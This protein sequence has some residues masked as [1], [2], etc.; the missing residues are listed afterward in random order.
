MTSPTGTNL[1][2]TLALR[3]YPF[4]NGRKRL[5]RILARRW[6]EPFLW[7]GRWGIRYLLVGRNYVDQRIARDGAYE[8]EQIDY[9]C[10]EVTRSAADVF[11]D[12]GAN[13]GVYSLSVAART[14]CPNIIAFEPDPY[15]LSQLQANIFLNGYC[16]RICVVAAGV[17]N[18]TGEAA[19]LV[20]RDDSD[21]CTA[22]SSM[23]RTTGGA[24]ESISI[25]TIALDDRYDW[26]GR[27]IVVKMDIEGHEPQALQGMRGVFARN[28]VL[29]QIEI[30]PE[31]EA[32]T[33]ATLADVGLAERPQSVP[34]S[35][36]FIFATPGW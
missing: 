32:R 30:L 14:A 12:I 19:L 10:G 13:L 7:T 21:L 16:E 36:D 17:S 24:E 15:N 22:R 26:S 2:S 35:R 23:E 4:R 3:A 33:R 34:G 29:L 8:G 1:I 5:I 28:Q 20:N 31:F 25:P 27:R 18:A 11:L 9:L 6:P